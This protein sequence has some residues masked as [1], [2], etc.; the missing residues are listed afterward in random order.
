MEYKY[1]QGTEGF[2]KEQVQNGK[3]PLQELTFFLLQP[4]DDDIKG[5]LPYYMRYDLFNIFQFDFCL[6]MIPTM[7]TWL[8]FA[9]FFGA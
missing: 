8:N 4:C 2:N 6:F 1:T 3:V 7:Y 9:L 5:L